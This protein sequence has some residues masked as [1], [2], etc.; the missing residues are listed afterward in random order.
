M[1]ISAYS[2]MMFSPTVQ[3]ILPEG[4]DSRKQI[5]AIF[6]L[7]LFGCLIFT[8]YAASLFF[9][10]KSKQLGILM[11]LGASRKRLTPGF[12]REVLILSTA[13][14]LLGSIA[15]FPLLW[16]FW[17]AFRI[18]LV[19]SPEMILHFNFSCLWIPVCFLLVVILFSCII[20][21]RYLHK[22]NIM[23]VI[24]EEHK[25]EPIRQPGR[26]Y[27][28]V[29]ILVLFIGAIGGYSST[30]I[31]MNLFHR[32]PTALLNITY[33]P[34]FVG[35]YMIM[36]H[37]VV[38][39]WGRKKKNPYK[40]IIARSMMKFQG[41]QTVNNLLVSTVLIVGACF[42]IFY[43]PILST[44]SILETNN[45]TWDYFFHYRADQKVP[46]Q[47]SICKMASDYGIDLTDW[48]NLDYISLALDGT[49]QVEEGR[50]FHDEYFSLLKEGK[51]IDENTYQAISGQKIDVKPGTYYGITDENETLSFYI[52]KNSTIL[53][54]MCTMEQFNTQYEGLLHCDIMSDKVGYYV[55]DSSDYKKIAS[56]LTEDWKGHLFCFNTAGEDSYEFARKLFHTFVDSFGPECEKIA[57]Y[58]RVEKYE[59]NKK[60]ETYWGDTD[61]MTKINFEHPDSTDFRIYWMYM[62]KIRIMDRN[63]FLQ[64]FAVFLMTFLFI[65]I[66]C[67]L[68]AMIISYTRCQTIAMNNRYVFDDLKRLGAS[69]EFLS[70]EV[71]NQ[72]E[73]VFT[74]PAIA[75]M[76]I[77]YLLYI[78]IMYAN[79]GKFQSAEIIGLI[80]CLGVL[81]LIAL[82]IS[83]IY[84]K[85]LRS[86]KKQLGIKV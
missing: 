67:I 63:D 56:G 86:I 24:H 77:M 62:P 31:Y 73:K 36:L 3:N 19:D 38:H 22:T 84:R 44:S 2:A 48:Q 42:G 14:S 61:Q 5:Y 7:S 71:K 81:L 15:G 20:A 26:W 9:C 32:Y 23:E 1:L 53:T 47:K 49:S 8:I 69:P 65:A 6:V 21:Y 51:F 54:N 83:V 78:M 52:A 74:I 55:L 43:I 79:D 29:G 25:N 82:L 76:S 27:G 28:P 37:T 11:A 75:G 80:I 59:N 64:S 33:V 70:R 35:L 45:R 72:C 13:S 46:D 66:I 41:K 50:S 60:G 12:F 58:D 4:G 18:F 68:A 34:V 40:N 17:R 10:K 30:G 85:T 16:L 39:G 57:M